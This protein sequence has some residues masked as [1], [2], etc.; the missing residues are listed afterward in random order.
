MKNLQKYQGSWFCNY[1]SSYGFICIY[2]QKTVTVRVQPRIELSEWLVINKSILVYNLFERYMYRCT[3]MDTYI[4][5]SS[6]LLS[7][8]PKDWYSAFLKLIN[9][10][11]LTGSQYSNK[12][13]RKWI[14]ESIHF[15]A[16]GWF[17]HWVRFL[18]VYCVSNGQLVWRFFAIRYL[19]KSLYNH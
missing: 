11:Q 16:G 6:V 1:S 12:H 17:F 8:V 19:F 3:I 18:A 7:H 14:K 10:G 4:S 13:R 5:D 15:G 2:R 9:I